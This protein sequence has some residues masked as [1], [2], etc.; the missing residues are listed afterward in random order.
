MKIL[1]ISYYFPP[2]GGPAVQRV[3]KF[4]KYLSRFGVE[5]FVLFAGHPFKIKDTS[6]RN[7]IP[8][9]V[10]VFSVTDWFSWL[11][12]DLQKLFKSS[13]LPDKQVFWRIPALMSARRI[14]QKYGIDLVLTSSPPHSV[15]LTGAD[16]KKKYNLKWVMDFRDEWSLDPGFKHPRP[17]EVRALE[18]DLLNQADAVVCVT[19]KAGTNFK[20]RNKST[21]IIR[22][23][24]DRED[25]WPDSSPQVI[26]NQDRLLMVY[27]G[28]LTVKSSPL[29][30]FKA[31]SELQ[32][33]IPEM[34]QAIRIEIYG[35]AENRQWLKNYPDLDDFV[36]F[37]PYQPH[38]EI[39]RIMAA[40]DVLL[41]FAG[42]SAESEVFPGKLYEYIYLR[43]PIFAVT[44]RAGELSA[45]LSAYGKA[46]TGLAEETGSVK[47]A[48][49]ALWH[50]WQNKSETQ[51][52]D[53]GF[54]DQFDREKQAGQLKMVFDSILQK[55]K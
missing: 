13:F 47:N 21:F 23:G 37:R 43:K 34:K 7:E 9:T 22:N 32:S 16:L 38:R 25:F 10:K 39:L 17:Q 45:F 3:A 5:V 6:L 44:N 54:V 15:H 12:G 28:R 31:L 42:N 4:V 19:D 48:L 29:P 49:L 35:S 1:L 27:A 18:H 11:P 55:G 41:L 2:E 26:P 14:C 30:F 53:D 24:F 20:G 8:D 50:S 52:V 33:E 46:F 51:V 40:A 36:S